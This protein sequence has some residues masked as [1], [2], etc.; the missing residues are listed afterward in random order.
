MAL[1]FNPA[2]PFPISGSQAPG[3]E[4]PSYREEQRHSAAVDQWLGFRIPDAEAR[5]LEQ[6][7]ALRTQPELS[8]E[9]W[10]GLDPQALL[11][12][13]TEL[14]RIIETVDAN[15]P[16]L[17][18]PP[19]YSWVDLGAAY[20]RLGIVL[21]RCRPT[22][23]FIGYESV[24]ERILEGRRIYSS[25]GLPADSLALADLADPAFA[26][27]AADFYFLYDYGSSQ[28]LRKTLSDLARLAKSRPISVI[29]RGR[30]S[31][32]L[33]D[34]EAP[35]LSQVNLPLHMGRWSWYRS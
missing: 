29:A 30:L 31:R 15:G 13:Y 34:Q 27:A 21:D 33:I 28:A 22:H 32:S 17:P 26:P 18:L 11:T 20:G 7:R 12:P 19:A 16:A 1:I 8:V 35:W 3:T 10:I 4:P 25:L 2:D 9:T 14:R 24:L 5:I 23:R 6:H